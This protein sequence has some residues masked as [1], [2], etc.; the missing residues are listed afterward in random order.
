MNENVDQ[1]LIDG[2]GIL[3]RLRNVSF[4]YGGKPV[5]KNVNLELKKGSSYSLIGQS[6][7]GKSTLL[8]LA[9]GFL[10]P[11]E[12]SIE[13]LSK[14]LKGTRKETA[15]M[16]QELALFPWQTVYQA[17]LMPLKMSNGK[18]KNGM[19][20]RVI[21]LLE[22]LGLTELKDKYPHQLSGGERQRT[23]LARGLIGEPDLL[24][25][26]EPTSSLDTVTKES[27]QE[28]I[29][30]QQ[31]KLQ[32]T[33]LFVTHDIEEALLLGEKILL[34]N[35]EGS[36]LTIDNPCYLRKQQRKDLAFYE[37][38]IYLKELLM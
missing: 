9:A 20:E 24:L 27:I 25:M 16:F 1:R 31:Q 14:P 28:L 10:R 15:I 4:D 8:N 18:D 22:E 35:G 12:G 30:K 29:R 13:I 21:K 33:L 19:E 17:A 32:A 23:A 5:I 7:T 3:A 6:G 26:D 2:S 36:V 38:C 37:Q 11:K 34:L